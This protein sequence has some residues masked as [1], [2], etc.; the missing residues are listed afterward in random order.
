M[1]ETDGEVDG[2]CDGRRDGELD[3]EGVM[4]GS[5]ELVGICETV[6]PMVTSDVGLAVGVP[7]P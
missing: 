5:T 6:G 1:C 3:I 7:H 4:E 2:I